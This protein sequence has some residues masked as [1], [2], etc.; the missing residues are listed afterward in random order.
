MLIPCLIISFS[1]LFIITNPQPSSAKDTWFT[2]QI[3]IDDEGVATVSAQLTLPAPPSTTYTELTDYPHWPELFPGKPVMRSISKIDDRVRVTMHI[4]AGY[5]P[6]NLELVTDTVQ[7]APLRLNTTL[8]EGDFEQYDWTWDLSQSP[9]G[10]STVAQ[11][12]LMVAPSIWVPDW[13]LR[14]LLESELATHFQ[15]LRERVFAHHQTQHQFQRFPP[16]R[17]N[18]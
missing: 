8:V 2:Q 14:W 15:L 13:L 5:L 7:T 9:S 10:D 1:F 12:L 6:L 16:Q 4:P 3:V 18:P 17:T 11:L